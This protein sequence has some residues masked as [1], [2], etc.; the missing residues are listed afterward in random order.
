[1]P[2]ALRDG[3]WWSARLVK[4]VSRAWVCWRGGA[5]VSGSAR[6]QRRAGRRGALPASGCG[7]C[8]GSRDASA[9]SLALGALAPGGVGLGVAGAGLNAPWEGSDG[10]NNFSSAAGAGGGSVAYQRRLQ[11]RRANRRGRRGC[12]RVAVQGGRRGGVSDSAWHACRRGEAVLLAQRSVED[13]HPEV[14]MTC[15]LQSVPQ[16]WKDTQKV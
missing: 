6:R 12:Y 2:R 5:A 8:T 10:P 1:M 14:L 15:Q 9:A 4:G 3:F 11:H 13:D 7:V 16:R